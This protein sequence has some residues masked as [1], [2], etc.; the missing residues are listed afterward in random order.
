[1]HKN[2]IAIFFT[3]LLMALM[4]APS[5]IIALDDTADTSMFYSLSEEEEASKIKP[6][7]NEGFIVTEHLWILGSL[8]GIVYFLKK[9]PKPYLYLISPP[10]EFIS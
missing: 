1:M 10:P 5:I 7:A 6:K 8:D 9:Y 2:A 3:M 4:S